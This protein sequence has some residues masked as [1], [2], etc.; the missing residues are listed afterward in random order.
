MADG[1]VQK[2]RVSAEE[3]MQELGTAIQGEAGMWGKETWDAIMGPTDPEEVA[4][5]QQDAQKLEQERQ[6]QI[7]VA[8]GNLQRIIEAE[9]LQRKKSTQIEQQRNA[10]EAQKV[11]EK[12]SAPAVAAAQAQKQRQ[13]TPVEFTERANEIKGRSVGG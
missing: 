10:Q 13:L 7:V 8:K 5:A 3:G 12:T 6:Q 4:R 1:I 11:Q 2:T 9:A